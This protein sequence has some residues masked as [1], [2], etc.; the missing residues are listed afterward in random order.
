MGTPERNASRQRHRTWVMPAALVG[1]VGHVATSMLAPS[2][3]AESTGFLHK[4]VRWI[5]SHSW[6]MAV[7]IHL[8]D[9]QEE[10]QHCVSPL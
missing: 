8:S 10:E 4:N 7:G 3:R 5:T 1:T 9:P 6:E 2:Q